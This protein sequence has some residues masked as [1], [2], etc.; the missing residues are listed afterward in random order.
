MR[1]KQEKLLVHYIGNQEIFTTP[2]L[3]IQLGELPTETQEAWIDEDMVNEVFK[4]P[5]K[6]KVDKGRIIDK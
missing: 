1:G 6:F 2:G 3:Q 4:N 5:K